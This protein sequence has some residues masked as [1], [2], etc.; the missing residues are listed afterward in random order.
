VRAGGTQVTEMSGMEDVEDAVREDD[1][2]SG[3]AG[4]LH[5]PLETGAIEDAAGHEVFLNVTSPEKRQLWRGR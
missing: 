2:R 3:G 5:E 1:S 4:V